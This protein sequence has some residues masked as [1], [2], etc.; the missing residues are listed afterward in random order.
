[1]ETDV[2]QTVIWTKTRSSIHL[3]KT[4]W[5][6]M[7]NTNR[8]VGNRKEKKGLEPE[9]VRSW[10]GSRKWDDV[11]SLNLLYSKPCP[12]LTGA[13]ASS[14]TDPSTSPT[15]PTSPQPSACKRHLKRKKISLKYYHLVLSCVSGIWKRLTW[16]DGLKTH[17]QSTCA[18]TRTLSKLS[19]II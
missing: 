17:W 9:V 10:T 5:E 12:R 8:R 15:P 14:P 1:M 4:E 7:T 16:F 2:T 11:I 6:K 13:S 19:Y 3:W 18:L